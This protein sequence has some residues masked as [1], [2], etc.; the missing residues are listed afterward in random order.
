MTR[1]IS[2]LVASWLLLPISLAAC[3]DTAGGGGTGSGEGAGSAESSCD[4]HGDC[5]PA[6][7]PCPGG[8]TVAGG[9]CEPTGDTGSDRA[10]VSAA[11]L[12]SRIGCPLDGSSASGTGGASASGV[13]ASS[14]G[15][16]E[17]DATS[18]GSGTTTHP[19]CQAY[20]DGNCD[21]T[22]T[23]ECPPEQYD[24]LV[25][26]CESFF[27]TEYMQCVIAC[28]TGGGTCSEKSEC[29]FACDE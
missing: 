7:C 23:G 29:A 5:A 9:V 17:D 27:E 22:Y 21:C 3:G 28:V 2:F 19:Q 13:S 14:T 8:T 12:C 15:S 11:E 25:G 18:S 20:A 24:E 10:C 16:G 4:V 1:S 26:Y 6:D